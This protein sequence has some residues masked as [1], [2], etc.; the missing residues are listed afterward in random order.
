MNM[1]PKEINVHFTNIKLNCDCE[2][3]ILDRLAIREESG[4]TF[5]D[6]S[7]EIVADGG[8]TVK[9]QLTEASGIAE[10]TE[11]DDKGDENTLFMK[12]PSIAN[13][14]KSVTAVLKT[15]SYLNDIVGEYYIKYR[16]E[17]E[18]LVEIDPM[19]RIKSTQAR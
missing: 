10:I 15:N 11:L 5:I 17:D 6:Y 9:W 8:E 1:D 16:L 18:T 4:E 12:T 7:Q 2:D 14:G 13:D 19:I 3:E